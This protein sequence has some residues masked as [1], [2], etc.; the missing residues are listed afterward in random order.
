MAHLS[1]FL[2]Q[3]EKQVPV[4]EVCFSLKKHEIVGYKKCLNLQLNL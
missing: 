3:K 2:S 1:V 4:K